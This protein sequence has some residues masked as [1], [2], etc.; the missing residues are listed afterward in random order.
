MK[1]MTTFVLFQFKALYQGIQG[2]TKT[3]G[4]FKLHSEKTKAVGRIDKVSTLVGGWGDSLNSVCKSVLGRGCQMKT[5]HY[6]FLS[7]MNSPIS[8]PGEG[9]E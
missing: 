9:A 6:F 7:K 3:L 4:F 2:T 1:Y 8:T 5:F